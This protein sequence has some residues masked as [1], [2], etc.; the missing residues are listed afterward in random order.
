MGCGTNER[1]WISVLRSANSCLRREVKRSFDSL[2]EM[3]L[4]I[5]LGI[6][7]AGTRFPGSQPPLGTVAVT[8]PILWTWSR[9]LMGVT[10][11]LWADF[12]S[13]YKTEGQKEHLLM[14]PPEC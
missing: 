10:S 14:I 13:L 7:G 8:M 6:P 1:G 9:T 11:Q 12:L 5:L 4:R 2:R 3:L